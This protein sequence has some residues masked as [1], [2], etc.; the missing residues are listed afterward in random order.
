MILITGASGLLGTHLAALVQERGRQIVGLYHRHVPVLQ[1]VR[2]AHV[3]LTNE[4]ELGRIFEEFEPRSVIHC[5]AETN[6][7]WCEEHPALAREI[8]VAVPRAVARITARTGARMLYISTDAVFDGTRGNYVETDHPSPVNVYAQTKLDGEREVLQENAEAAIARVN[9]YGRSPRQKPSLAEWILDRLLKGEVVPAF[10]DVI[11]CPIHGT[12]LAQVLL[13]IVDREFSGLYHV[14]GSEAVSKY[15]F[16]KRIA[17]AFA[18][19]PEL[20]L[21]ARL[22]DAK[23]KAPRP[24]NTSLNTEKLSA[25]LGR[26]LPG[27]DFGLRRFAS[28]AR[29]WLQPLT[30]HPTE[31]CR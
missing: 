14:V 1:G 11:F 6:V 4:A 27:L 7:D 20:V 28:Q 8:N 26:A 23:L 31:A 24:R 2:V 3:D 12:D 18:F 25:A 29:E 13:D 15:D 21:P 30:N 22:A 19:D 17:G 10:T 9:L 5:A 16:A